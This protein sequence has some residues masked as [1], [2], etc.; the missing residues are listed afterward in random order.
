MASRVFTDIF[1]RYVRCKRSKGKPPGQIGLKLADLASTMKNRNIVSPNEL[2]SRRSRRILKSRSLS[3]FGTLVLE[4]PGTF[5]PGPEPDDH[6]RRPQS[7]AH[8]SN[9]GRGVCKLHTDKLA[10]TSVSIYGYGTRS[11]D[12]RSGVSTRTRANWGRSARLSARVGD[13]SSDEG[14]RED[15]YVAKNR[16][17]VLT[18]PGSKGGY[19]RG[20]SKDSGRLLRRNTDSTSAIRSSTFGSHPVYADCDT[21]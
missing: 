4:L 15:G 16:S 17:E 13:G 19:V 14:E 2:N 3:P 18:L 21:L 9:V 11:S 12:C 7:R 6:L 10:N 5:R 1:I 20:I 8:A